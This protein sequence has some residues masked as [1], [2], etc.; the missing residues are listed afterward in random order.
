MILAVSEFGNYHAFV[1]TRN[2]IF[3]LSDGLE[4]TNAHAAQIS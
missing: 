2:D 1:R 3:Y 4:E